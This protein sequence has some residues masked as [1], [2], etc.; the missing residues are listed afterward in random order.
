MGVGLVLSLAT[1]VRDE[2][3]ALRGHAGRNRRIRSL[4]HTT[5]RSVLDGTAAARRDRIGVRGRTAVA[6]A[7]VAFLAFTGYLVLGATW[8]YFNPVEY[9]RGLAGLWAAGAA[10][11]VLA[12]A[13][14]VALA[15]S[16]AR[17]SDLPA[18]VRPVLVASRLTVAPSPPSAEG[19]DP[20]RRG[21]LGTGA[22]AALLA[23]A[24]VTAYVVL[25]TPL[26][27]DE[28]L[29]R[30]VVTVEGLAVL[31]GLNPFASV[32][33][34]ALASA[35]VGLA[36]WRCRAFAGTF[37]LAIAVTVVLTLGTNRLVDRPRPV[38]PDPSSYP[39]AHIATA[40]LMT[41]LVPLAVLALTHRQR[42]ARLAGAVLGVGLVGVVVERLV[43]GA[44]WPTDALAALLVAAAVVAS[45]R[46]VLADPRRHVRCRRC[47]WQAPPLLEGAQP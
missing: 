8:N 36:T 42:L 11:I 45:V 43:A 19:A 32:V 3:H 47:P 15:V 13:I 46:F 27:L 41:G 26:A 25:G 39:S 2:V 23:F 7:A 1:L 38:L 18:Q 21:M 9:F 33:S 35:A 10:V 29:R 14:G 31:R 5:A 4:G 28:P 17:W 6:V 34:A 44:H 40:A 12:G 22:A 37:L 24:V 20:A 30:A 16:A